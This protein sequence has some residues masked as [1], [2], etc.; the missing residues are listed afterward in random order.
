L[1]LVGLDNHPVHQQ[2]GREFDLFGSFLLVGSAVA[3]VSRLPRLLSAST[4]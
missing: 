4:R 2:L 3:M 1:Q